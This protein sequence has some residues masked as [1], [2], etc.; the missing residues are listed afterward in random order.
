MRYDLHT[1]SIF[2]D[3]TW[4]PQQ[5]LAAAAEQDLVVALTDHNTVSGLPIF[6]ET[7]E[8]MGV[9]AVPGIEFSTDYLDKD[10]HI[11]AL[12]VREESY[13]AIRTYVAKGDLA[14]EQSNRDLVARLQAAGYGLDYD[15][16][17]A[18]TPDGRINR[19]NVAGELVKKG[20]VP[21]VQAA[22]SQLLHPK[23]GFYTPPV[24]PGAWDTVAFI[25]SIGALPVLAHPLLTMGEEMLRGFL[26]EAK[27]RGLAA[28]ETVYSSYDEETAALARQIAAEF[29][30]L[31]SGG[32]DFHGDRKPD[33]HL[34][35]PA[36]SRQ[37]FENLRAAR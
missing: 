2:S 23:H 17:V 18:Q 24:R 14:K 3:G 10:V 7:A 4:T 19:A 20:Y 12:F 29:G 37:A 1:H 11:L 21:S 8:K 15:E 30:L 9:E 36:I 13:D 34:G 16:L 28:M 5:L 25:R 31:S 35:C 6:L 22:F 26:P 27:A 33:V 32:S